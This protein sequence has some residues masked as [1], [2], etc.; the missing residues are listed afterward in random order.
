MFSLDLL[1]YFVLTLTQ[2]NVFL[3]LGTLDI[4]GAYKLVAGNKN[5]RGQLHQL[6]A[7]EPRWDRFFHTIQIKAD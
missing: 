2:K 5:G 4:A 7:R 3:F 6:S 1:F